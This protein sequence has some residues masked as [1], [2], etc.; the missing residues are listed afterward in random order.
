[1]IR[2]CRVYSDACTRT[3]RG[4]ICCEASVP[5]ARAARYTQVREATLRDQNKSTI[6]RAAHWP[7][8]ERK[9]EGA[10]GQRERE[11]DK[12]TELT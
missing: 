7:T 10:R 4:T 6:T 1:M 8:P 9:I 5:E 12:R 11:R 2:I 3:C